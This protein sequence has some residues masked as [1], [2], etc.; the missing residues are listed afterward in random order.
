LLRDFR[1]ATRSEIRSTVGLVRFTT[2]PNLRA[3]TLVDKVAAM[4]RYKIAWMPGDGV[5]HDV[6]EAARLRANRNKPCNLAVTKRVARLSILQRLT[7][8]LD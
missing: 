6:M 1:F 8:K 5:G 2:Q 3:I 4:S 7:F